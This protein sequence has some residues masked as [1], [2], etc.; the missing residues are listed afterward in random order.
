[1]SVVRACAGPAPND[2]R[3]AWIEGA[4]HFAARVGPDAQRYH[5]TETAGL[6]HAMLHASVDRASPGRGR[7]IS[8]EALA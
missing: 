5:V 1:M 7:R 2:E 3:D 6:G 4:T 8:M